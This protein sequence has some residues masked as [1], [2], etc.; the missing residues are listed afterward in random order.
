MNNLK[1]YILVFILLLTLGR[2]Y[3]QVPEFNLDF[4]AAKSRQREEAYRL[5]RQS[6]SEITNNQTKYD[7][8]YY[9]LNLSLKID[10]NSI[11]GK[12][13]IA[14][15]ILTDSLSIIELNFWD[16]MQVNK[17]YRTDSLAHQLIYRHRNDL[18]S[19]QLD[20]LYLKGENF[21]ISISY[22]G[23]P[24]NNPY[25]AFQFDRYQEEPMIWTLNE[26]FGARAWF[27]CKDVPSDKAD[28]MDIRV[29]VPEGLTVASNG[30]LRDKIEKSDSTTF[31]W[32][33]EYPITTYLVSL[34][35]YPYRQF[36]DWYVYGDSDSMEVQYYV[37]PDRY[38]D[39]VEDYAQTVSMIEYFSSIFGQYPFLKEKYGHAE[40]LW[41]GGM[42]HQTLTSLGAASEPLI[43]HELAHQWW[44]DAVTCHTFH[45]LWLNEGFASYSEALWFEYE[46]AD[47]TASQYQMDAQYFGPGTIYIEDLEDEKL[48]D[49]GLRY[50]KASWVL[51]M[52]RHIVG[53]DIFFD[54][55]KAYYE[56]NKFKYQSATTE[57]FIELCNQISGMDLD[58][59]FQQWIFGEYYP[60]YSY[61]WNFTKNDSGYE[62]DL[63]I[64][65]EQT[66]TGLFRMPL[67]IK[68]S[69]VS[70]DYIFTVMD[71]ARTQD[72]QF[73]TATKPRNIE[74]DPN[75]WI[76]K[77]VEHKG[78]IV[79]GKFVENYKL[80]Q[81]YPNPFNEFTTISF[82]LPAI[83]YVSLVIYDLQGQKVAEPLGRKMNS[84]FHRIKFDGTNLASGVYFYKLQ[85]GDFIET[86]K[87]MLMK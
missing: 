68:I 69:T 85:A 31:W 66:N 73:F 43:A 72:F 14:G 47:Y 42:E 36:S 24:G 19:I 81:N 18:L 84:G 21:N 62:I 63:T 27:P 7:I 13:R 40:F 71:S 46:Y 8:K 74:L 61:S 11:T 39:R 79:N 53:D 2:L 77:K 33:E 9:G 23:A 50:N 56:S 16:G 28:S 4:R 25:G 30:L 38:T 10:S 67:D 6:L 48:F 3:S 37:F 75:N 54:I 87:M 57:Q 58:Y 49:Y 34:A 17:V 44:G 60:V 29:T 12:I 64:N 65:Q 5:Y 15:E 80:Y 70:E 86:K 83:D 52:L 35:V 26:P 22:R 55:L 45:D 82:N 20:T 76:L 32:H 51:H 41:P 59:F 1:K 78:Y